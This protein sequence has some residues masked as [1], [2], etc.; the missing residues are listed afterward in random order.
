MPLTGLSGELIES[1]LAEADG[2]LEARI[3]GT[4]KDGEDRWEK[5]QDFLIDTIRAYNPDLLGGVSEERAQ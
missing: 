3:A 1:F 4:A 2:V 5:R